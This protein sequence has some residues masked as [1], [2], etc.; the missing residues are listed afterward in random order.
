MLC[1]YVFV[2]VF[3]AEAM[4]TPLEINGFHML[5]PCALIH[6][7]YTVLSQKPG[8][9]S[10]FDLNRLTAHKVCRITN[11]VSLFL[12]HSFLPVDAYLHS[13]VA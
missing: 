3:S 9:S 11:S 5:C 13:D 2:C 7:L 1:A 10:Q 4:Q 12:F 6:Q 8:L